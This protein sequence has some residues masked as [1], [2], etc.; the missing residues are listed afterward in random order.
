MNLHTL[1]NLYS[2]LPAVNSVPIHCLM[3]QRLWMRRSRVSSHE[4]LRLCFTSSKFE[5]DPPRQVQPESHVMLTDTRNRNSTGW[6]WKRP[7]GLN[8]GLDVL[9]QVERCQCP[10]SREGR[11]GLRCPPGLQEQSRDDF[12][13]ARH[14]LSF[15]SLW[16]PAC[17]HSAR[18]FP[19]F[20]PAT[21]K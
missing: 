6:V 16:P 8:V 3:V 1:Q 15:S 4:D 7:R 19:S 17:G 18:I 10:G 21:Y 20:S 14:Q 9:Q 11:P 13:S 2:Y 12:S 5:E